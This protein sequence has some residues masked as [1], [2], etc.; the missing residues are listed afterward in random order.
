M[1]ATTAKK[2]AQQKVLQEQ[3]NRFKGTNTILTPE[4]APRTKSPQE[5]GKRLD[6]SEFEGGLPPPDPWEVPRNVR[7]ELSDVLHPAGP[8]GPPAVAPKP[9]VSPRNSIE[10]VP[11]LPPLLVFPSVAAAHLFFFFRSHKAALSPAG[12]VPVPAPRVKPAAVAAAAAA[13][14]ARP[15]PSSAPSNQSPVCVFVSLS[16]GAQI[17]C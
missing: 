15:A 6:Y 11:R 13:N 10:V 3:Q 9:Q 16:C 12:P 8:P 17:I 2:Q 4:P 7:E 1:A 14:G 5:G